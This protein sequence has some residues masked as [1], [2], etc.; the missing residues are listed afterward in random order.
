MSFSSGAPAGGA[1]PERTDSGFTLVE[2][3]I[4]IGLIAFLFLA[5]AMSLGGALRAVAVQKAR[6][7]GN[8]VATQ[9]IEDL[10]R[11]AYSSLMLCGSPSAPAGE[12]ELDDSPVL[13][14][15]GTTGCATA[16]PLSGD[17]PCN[18]S[19]NLGFPRARYDCKRVNLTYEVRRYVAWTDASKTTKRMAVYVDWE[20]A[21]GR[22]QV[23]Q[24]SSL[25]APVVG[26]I[27]GISPPGFT[28]VRVVTPPTRDV[29]MN[30]AGMTTTPI[31]FQAESSGLTSAANDRVY[32]S[33][34][35]IED[36]ELVTRTHPL[37]TAVAVP[38]G[39]R[40]TGTLPSNRG[41]F[42]PGTQYFTFTA[43]RDTDGKTGSK[44]DSGP[45][46]FR[47]VGDACAPTTQAP[48]LTNVTQTQTAV[49]IALDGA[50]KASWTVTAET[51][52]L[53]PDDSVSVQFMTRSGAVSAALGVDPAHAGSCSA[54]NCKWKL[55]L[56]VGSPYA[57]KAETQT[58]ALAA[59]S[60]ATRQTTA[61]Q[62][63]PIT[64][65]AS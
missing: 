59:A 37:P 36:G 60:A 53:G 56:P 2:L 22:H 65:T 45:T 41:P 28:D 35:V 34:Q 63:N 14:P 23:S 3:V 25:R 8:E 44:I 11:Y 50:L 57:F 52:N 38:G 4:A 39:L 61:G 62:S 43:V 58:V 27:V 5:I 31:T 64:F 6:T 19:V 32:V 12:P 15:S 1:P 48:R 18:G 46:T 17:E 9:G 21:G 29:T 30:D 10:Q 20:D 49:S 26:D 33:F 7:Q 42:P 13:L 47:C 24:Q 55:V 51:E 16:S 40:W 54:I